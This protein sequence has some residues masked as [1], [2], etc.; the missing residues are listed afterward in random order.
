[1]VHSNKIF[2]KLIFPLVKWWFFGSGPPWLGLDFF[3]FGIFFLLFF[4]SKWSI[5]V[6]NT[7]IYQYLAKTQNNF[8]STQTTVIWFYNMVLIV[9]L[10]IWPKWPFEVLRK[11]LEDSYGKLEI[12]DFPTSNVFHSLFKFFW[13]LKTYS[14]VHFANW[15]KIIHFCSGNQCW[16]GPN[17]TIAVILR[18]IIFNEMLHIGKI[19]VLIHKFTSIGSKSN[20]LLNL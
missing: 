18:L 14:P 4:N 11:Y 7:S 15:L 20:P 12:G 13:Q 1:M 3:I 16:K 6:Q 2:K 17:L 8:F 19:K 9:T 5:P 10:Q